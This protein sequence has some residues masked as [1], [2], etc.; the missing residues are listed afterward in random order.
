[1]KLLE[2][3]VTYDVTFTH[4]DLV[5]HAGHLHGYGV[6]VPEYI[7]AITTVDKF[8]GKI[9]EVIKKRE[10]LY[11]EDWL[12]IIC[13]DHGGMKNPVYKYGEEKGIH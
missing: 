2:K 13:S 8:V 12:T 10:L 5:D 9:W 3:E 7:F 6:D 1:V 4:F 11:K